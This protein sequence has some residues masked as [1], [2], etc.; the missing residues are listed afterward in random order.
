MSPF[1]V[2][3][4]KDDFY[5]SASQ[6]FVE[7]KY[8]QAA[9]LEKEDVYFLTAGP[10]FL[11]RAS[12][13]FHRCWLRNYGHELDVRLDEARYCEYPI[14]TANSDDASCVWN[15]ENNSMTWA[16][17][18]RG[19]RTALV[20]SKMDGP[21]FMVIVTFRS[22]ADQG[23]QIGMNVHTKEVS[24]EVLRQVV[25]E[26]ILHEDFPHEQGFQLA[27]AQKVL[28]FEDRL[29][30]IRVKNEMVFD[31]NLFILDLLFSGLKRGNSETAPESDQKRTK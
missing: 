20:F 21:A 26:E 31:E 15:Y 8:S 25:L 28:P 18:W 7:V 14:A 6:N 29:M 27:E 1:K 23:G 9:A 4:S 16:E 5:R 2:S 11:R 17:Y 10:R 3:G 30:T 19:S 22:L 12:R 13:A 24:R